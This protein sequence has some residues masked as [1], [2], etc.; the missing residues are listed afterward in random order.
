MDLSRIILDLKF[1]N[2]FYFSRCRPLRILLNRRQSNYLSDSQCDVQLENFVIIV[3]FFNSMLPRFR[4]K[5][6]GE[7]ASCSISL[8]AIVS[9]FSVFITAWL[10]GQPLLVVA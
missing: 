7:L 8:P 6:L 5:R 3:E 1:R 10:K 9:Q 4:N 2:T